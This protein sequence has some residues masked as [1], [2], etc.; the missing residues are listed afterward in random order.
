M[1]AGHSKAVDAASFG[2]VKVQVIRDQKVKNLTL[3]VIDSTIIL[4]NFEVDIY[5]IIC[6][7]GIGADSIALSVDK[8]KPENAACG[9]VRA[10]LESRQK[11]LSLK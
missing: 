7:K 3:K 4:H 10:F 5:K 11:T 1:G 6:G 8:E 2:D 9:K